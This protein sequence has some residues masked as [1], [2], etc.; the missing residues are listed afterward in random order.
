MEPLSNPPALFYSDELSPRHL[1]SRS[2]HHV[3]VYLI[4]PLLVKK[5]KSQTHV[6]WPTPFLALGELPAHR[7]VE[8]YREREAERQCFCRVCSLALRVIGS[9]T[10]PQT[11]EIVSAEDEGP[12]GF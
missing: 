3:F 6:V 10:S 9:H 2:I 8:V 1:F 11:S 4:V 7:S 12:K 5:K